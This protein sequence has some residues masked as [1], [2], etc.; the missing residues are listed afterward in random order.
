MRLN[1]LVRTALFRLTLVYIAVF[2][3]SALVLAMGGAYSVSLILENSVR[4][5]VEEE[6]ESLAETFDSDGGN[7]LV[8]ELQARLSDRK[9]L[10]VINLV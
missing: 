10:A 4:A 5:D 6:L 1:A 2:M 7:R 9:S 3:G 8:L